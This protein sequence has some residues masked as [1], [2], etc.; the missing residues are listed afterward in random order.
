MADRKYYIT[1]AN[2]TAED[3]KVK[4]RGDWRGYHAIAG[5][6]L[7]FK[8]ALT[9]Y[10]IHQEQSSSGSQALRSGKINLTRCWLNLF[11]SGGFTVNVKD[12]S[13]KVESQY[14]FTTRNQGTLSNELGLI[15]FDES[16]KKY[17]FP[18]VGNNEDMRITIT[19]DEPSPICITGTGFKGDYVNDAR[20]I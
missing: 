11:N 1:D 18:V 16:G 12:E 4:L 15:P 20:D 13:S 2:L 3:G 9:K 7:P 8:C 14:H 17:E 6:K 19:S 5:L 10:Y